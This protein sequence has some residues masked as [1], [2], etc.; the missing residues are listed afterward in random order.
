MIKC[1][2]LIALIIVSLPFSGFAEPLRVIDSVGRE[3]ILQL[4]A[5]RI[6]ALS[7][8]IVEN[9]FSAGAGDKLVGVVS[10]SNYPPAAN[11]IAIVG[12]S[13]AFSLEKI[14]SLR[15]DLV[16]SWAQG[17]GHEVAKPFAA[18]GIPVYVDEPRK[19]E[20]V[21]TSVRNI[22][23]LTGS[24]AQANAIADIFMARLSSLQRKYSQQALVSVF[25]QVWNK[26]LQTINEKHI[27][28]SVIQLCGG[29]NIFTDTPLIAPK[30]SLEA[31]I[32]RDPDVI[33]ASGMDQE[34][35]EWLDEWREFPKLSAVVRDNLY[36]IP[37]DILQ[38]HTVRILLGAEKM[39][40]SLRRAREKLAA[41][42][43]LPSEE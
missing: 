31:V 28:S 35:P 3:V 43:A 29:R 39:C 12:S 15:P 10:Y 41:T 30:V 19:L 20:D 22:G 24:T 4:P 9:V 21:A 27:I 8:H 11:D 16:L 25:Y 36:F 5:Q 13:Q 34:R 6:I 33:I 14:V 38:R 7:P 26:P 32:S 18:L 17:D 40:E 42:A 37:P 23:V 2:A 1:S